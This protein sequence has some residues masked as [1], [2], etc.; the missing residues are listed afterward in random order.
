MGL[1]HLLFTLRS[2]LTRAAMLARSVR[3]PKRL[4]WIAL[5]L[6]VFIIS[7]LNILGDIPFLGFLDDAALLG[8]LLQWF[9]R[10]AGAFEPGK[11]PFAP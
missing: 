8:F 5:G 4:K 11:D 7:P 1:I 3:V 9:V 10:T 2:T 6:A